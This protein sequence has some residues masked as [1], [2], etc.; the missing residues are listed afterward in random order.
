MEMG[1]S[2]G[3]KGQGGKR[4]AGGREGGRGKGVEKFWWR[5]I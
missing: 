2:E 4:R 3:R 1:L 5:E